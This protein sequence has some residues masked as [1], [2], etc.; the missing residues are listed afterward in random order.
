MSEK[1]QNKFKRAEIIGQLK[2]NSQSTE[3]VDNNMQQNQLELNIERIEPSHLKCCCCLIKFDEKNDKLLISESHVVAFRN[4]INVE[5][6]LDSRFSLFI[7]RTCDNRLRKLTEFVETFGNI[8]TKFN[9]FVDSGMNASEVEIDDSSE[10]YDDDQIGT[11]MTILKTSSVECMKNCSVRLERLDERSIMKITFLKAK[12]SK[13]ENNQK[14]RSRLPPLVDKIFCCDLCGYR[15]SRK[16][17]VA[18]HMNARHYISKVKCE[19]CHKVYD[20]RPNLIFTFGQCTTKKDRHS[21]ACFAAQKV[22]N[23]K[24]TKA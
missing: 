9:D 17:N 11:H 22:G 5:L 16:M 10:F 13:E 4:I 20:R 19:I 23:I 14:T 2:L 21:S 15:S 7:C 8:Q 6:N 12:Y 3:N 18:T 1:V 24:S